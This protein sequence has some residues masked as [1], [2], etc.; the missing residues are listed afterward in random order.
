MTYNE[1]KRAIENG[2]YDAYTDRVDVTIE[3]SL[4]VYGILRNPI[5]NECL[6]CTPVID[7]WEMEDDKEIQLKSVDV[8]KED[9]ID[10]LIEENRS[11]FFSF[12]G[13]DMNTELDR[14]EDNCFAHIIQSINLYDGWF[15]N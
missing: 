10:Y 12:I 8:T 2:D 1:I 6:F 7:N 13:S 3:I 11:A 15:N 9:V 14:L 5:T 4:F